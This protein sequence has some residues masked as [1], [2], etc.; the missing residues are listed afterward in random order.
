M[1][2][3]VLLQ[4]AFGNLSFSWRTQASDRILLVLRILAASSLVVRPLSL[5]VM[6]S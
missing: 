2:V 5:H 4:L 3:P 6:I 1:C